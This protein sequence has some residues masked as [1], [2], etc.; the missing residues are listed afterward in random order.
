MSAHLAGSEDDSVVVLLA[1]LFV[2]LQFFPTNADSYRSQCLINT[3]VVP[4]L[5]GFKVFFLINN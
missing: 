4:V 5:W 3:Q 1:M 2:I